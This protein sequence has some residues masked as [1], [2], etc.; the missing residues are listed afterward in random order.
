MPKDGFPI[1]DQ[2]ETH[3]GAFVACCHS[4]VTLAANHAFEIARMVQHGAL[5]PELVGAFSARRFAN[6]VEANG[7]GYY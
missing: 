7:S 4:G 5:E 3:P 6:E 1:Y 2:S